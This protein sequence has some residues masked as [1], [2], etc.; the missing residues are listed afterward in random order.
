VTD[1]SLKT[2]GLDGVPALQPLTYPGALITEPGLLRDDELLELHARPERLGRWEVVD[3]DS[4]R[5]TL[6]AM[7]DGLGQATAGRRFPV[8]AIGSNASPGQVNFKLTRLGLPAVVPMAPVRIGGIGVGVSG[9]ISPAGYV[10]AS[11]FVAPQS[12]ADVVVTWLDARQLEA[13]DKTEYPEYRRIL[14][15]GKEYPIVLPSGERLGA[16]YLYVNANGVLVDDHG[17]PMPTGEQRR[18]LT[19]LLAR[20]PRLRELFASP[21][22]W[23]AR[24]GQDPELRAEGLKVFNE[25][26]WVLR[27]TELL[28][29]VGETGVDLRYDDV[30][31]LDRSA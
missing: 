16:V 26:G 30:S 6:D 8:A 31:S 13:V 28:R 2:L 7:L 3:G 18:I 24:A 9:H 1:R 25:S 15:S 4:D 12:V 10:A 20:S 14:L 27:Q 29:H 11:P 22:E 17:R 23:V 5:T 19:A 21:E